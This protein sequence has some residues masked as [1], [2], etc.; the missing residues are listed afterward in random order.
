MALDQIAANLRYAVERAD[1]R[2]IELTRPPRAKVPKE[3]RPRVFARPDE[4]G[5]RMPGGLFGQRRDMQASQANVRATAAVMVG[6]LVRALRGS[7][8]NLNYDQVG[9]V[10][11]VEGFNVLV[12]QTDV[13]VI[14]EISGE[15]GKP[16]RR[17]QGI[18][19][20]TPERAFGFGQRRQ[21]HFD[22]HRDASCVSLL[23]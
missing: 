6:D 8:V 9:L 23:N 12:L 11:Q 16:Q 1:R 22:F 15:S 10:V 14:V 5:V 2:A 21:D 13:V 20:R 18:F 17:K 19:D 7:D 4:N 3:D